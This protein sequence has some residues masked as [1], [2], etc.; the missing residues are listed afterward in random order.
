VTR[1]CQIYSMQLDTLN[2]LFFQIKRIPEFYHS[3][4]EQFVEQLLQFCFSTLSFK[5][6]TRR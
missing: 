5:R 3:K 2:T 4:D 1:N 6:N